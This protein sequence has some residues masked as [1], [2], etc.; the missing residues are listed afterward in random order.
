MPQ[1][2]VN[3]SKVDANSTVKINAVNT[4]AQHKFIDADSIDAGD[5]KPVAAPAAHLRQ[6]S[7]SK[8]AFSG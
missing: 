3:N 8:R 7:Q 1:W 5:A 4:N 2:W 6:R